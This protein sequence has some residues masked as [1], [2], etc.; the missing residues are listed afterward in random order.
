[1]IKAWLGHLRIVNGDGASVHSID[2]FSTT[3]IMEMN[4]RTMHRQQDTQVMDKV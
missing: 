3:N 2:H 1:M 4:S